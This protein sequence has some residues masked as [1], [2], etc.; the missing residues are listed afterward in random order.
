MTAMMMIRLLELHFEPT[1]QALAS[2][3]FQ[4]S[5]TLKK[6]K[7]QGGKGSENGTGGQSSSPIRGLSILQCLTRRKSRWQESPVIS[8]SKIKMD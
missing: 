3:K 8:S 4:S 1:L 7:S 5:A 2:R 6:G